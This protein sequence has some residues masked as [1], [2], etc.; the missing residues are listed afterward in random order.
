MERGIAERS[1]YPAI[2]V[3]KPLSRTMPCAADP[4]YVP[5]ITQPGR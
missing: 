4:A 5:L 1:R 2:N 3:L